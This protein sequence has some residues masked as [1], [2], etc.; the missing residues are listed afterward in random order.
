M[1]LYLPGDVSQ[2]PSVIVD[3]DGLQES[4]ADFITDETREYLQLKTNIINGEVADEDGKLSYENLESF[5]NEALSFIQNHQD[6]PILSDVKYMYVVA[7]KMYTDI[8]LAE[9]GDIDYDDAS[10]E[11]LT[12]Y[13]NN[14]DGT[15]LATVIKT[16]L[17]DVSANG[18]L[19]A[20]KQL[21]VQASLS[22]LAD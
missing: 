6:F 22:S 1:I 11:R 20:D 3:Y 13:M 19:T 14:H 15:P 18:K 10:V 8:Y 17:D 7:A 5:M 12:T 4:Y 2:S 9:E 21:E 16:I